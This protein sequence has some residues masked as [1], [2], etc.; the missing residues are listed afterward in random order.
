MDTGMLT[1][2][3]VLGIVVCICAAQ[4]VCIERL[5]QRALRA[6]KEIAS[7]KLAAAHW[8]REAHAANA[9]LVT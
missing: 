4:T 9:D 8:E 5:Y 7:W 2:A 3:V 6:E 1:L